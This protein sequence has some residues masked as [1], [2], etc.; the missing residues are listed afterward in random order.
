MS[1]LNKI[2]PNTDVRRSIF[3]HYLSDLDRYMLFYALGLKTSP[4]KRFS[5]GDVFKNA[6]YARGVENS[7]PRH[8]TREAAKNGH[9]EVLRWLVENGCLWDSFACEFAA[10]N[11]H[12]EVLKWAKEAGGPWQNPD[13]CSGAARKGHLEVLKWARE[14]GC[15]E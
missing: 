7:I 13:V 6:L 3:E 4:L 15:P 14:N 10:L 8:F 9:L 5:N 11:G 1:V 12:L 2:C